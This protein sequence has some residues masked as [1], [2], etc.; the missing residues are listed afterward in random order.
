MIAPA[1][2]LPSSL[3]DELRAEIEQLR[4]EVADLRR[5]VVQ[6]PARIWMTVTEAA[7]HAHRTERC[8]RGWCRRFE[9]GHMRDGR[10]CVDPERLDALLRDWSGA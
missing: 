6:R 7:E 5:T 1:E 8:V 3:V 4:G 2:Q 9:I 10:W